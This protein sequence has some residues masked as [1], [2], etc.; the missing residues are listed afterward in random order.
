MELE[1]MKNEFPKM[2]VEIKQ[3]IETEVKKQ[4]ERETVVPMPQKSLPKKK[5]ALVVLVAVMALGTTVFAA[6]RY[7]QMKAEK[8]GE[9]GVETYIESVETEKETGEDEQI[10][11]EPVVCEVSYVP[12][13]MVEYEEQKYGYADDP[14]EG[15]LTIV[16]YEMDMGD[17]AFK[18][19]DKDI[20]YQENLTI[21]GKDAIYLEFQSMV[22]EGKA[23]FKKLYVSYP[24]EHYVMELFIFS[25]VT[26]EEGIK[27]AEGISLRPATETDEVRNIV[28]DYT[29]SEYLESLADTDDNL[30]W[31]SISK[32]EFQ[33][34]SIGEKLEIGSVSA[35]VEKVEIY[36]NINI[37]LPGYVDNDLYKM[38]VVDNNGKLL[39]ATKN[40]YKRGD[41]INTLDEL[42][43]TEKVAQKLVY[44]TVSYTN[45]GTKDLKE[46]LFNGSLLKAVEDGDK[47]DIWEWTLDDG[48]QPEYVSIQNNDKFDGEMYY[49]DVHGGERNNN[50]IPSIK[51]GETVTVHMGFIVME[52]ELPSMYLNL[53][54]EGGCLEFSEAALELGY[55]DIRQ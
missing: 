5:L 27:F 25:N 22:E 47:L 17:D 14:L 31:I 7:Y 54:N 23:P 10:E 49:Y 40:Y 41:G 38:G 39:D 1:N 32:D 9:Y 53:A 4:V 52:E 6:V 15:G 51:A 13:G 55:V 33:T 3:M 18:M 8:I 21:G 36:D 28:S 30:G 12:E 50:Y 29:W 26:K 16:F 11:I 20:T 48:T 45:N 37:L 43:K 42:I 24:N 34:R 44:V 2:P 35:C 19:M 46:V